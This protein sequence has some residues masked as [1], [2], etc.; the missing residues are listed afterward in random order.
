ML[1]ADCIL[2]HDPYPFLKGPFA[3]YSLISLADSSAGYAHANG[4][5]WY[6]Q[7]AKP[8]GPVRRLTLTLTPTLPLT[9]NP[10][11]NPNPYPYP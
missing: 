8:H 3:N 1:D 5:V 9:P 7:G 2:F 4:G 11:P 6:A 10:N